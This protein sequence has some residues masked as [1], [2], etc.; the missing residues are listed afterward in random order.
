MMAPELWAGIAAA[1]L[2]LAAVAGGL[3]MS[4]VRGRWEAIVIGTRAAALAAL[5]V[6]LIA[7][8]MAQ[9]RW[10]AADPRQAVLSLVAAMLAVHLLLAWRLGAAGGGPMIDIAA[11]ALSLASLFAL[12]AG[13]SSPLCGRQAF[14][15][16]AHWVLLSLGG[17]SALV[18]G[19]AGLTLALKKGLA[20]RGRDLQ[21]PGWLPL[22]GLLSQAAVLA[23]VALGSGL[24]AGVWW[25]WR[26]SGAM[27]GS[28]AREVWMAVAWLTSAMSVLAWQLDGRRSRWAAGLALVA[29]AAVLV[30]LLFPA[31]WS[32]A[33]I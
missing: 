5:I 33:G 8:A 12:Q 21:R 19:C 20:W 18:A 27:V 15:L 1:F 32:M 2:G 14:L 7:A 6:A 11:L 26:A 22:V 17:G 28:G 29:G 10:T 25:A 4:A 13:A 9:G 24:I 23:V 3:A 31:G 30:G 16:Q